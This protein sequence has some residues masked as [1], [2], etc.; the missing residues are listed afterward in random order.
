MS[1]AVVPSPQDLEQLH[2]KSLE[3]VWQDWRT[4]SRYLTGS[5]SSHMHSLSL[6][7][8]HARRVEAFTGWYC[9]PGTSESQSS[10]A[11]IKSVVTEVARDMGFREGEL[12]NKLEVIEALLGHD[13]RQLLE[14]HAQD[15]TLRKI[16]EDELEEEYYD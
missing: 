2:A 3:L 8:A 6:K 13:G 9:D 5:A 7:Y 4:H 1:V 14:S 15:T 16:I 11:G 12:D 10:H